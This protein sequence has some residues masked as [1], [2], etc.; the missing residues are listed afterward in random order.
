MP[1]LGKQIGAKNSFGK[2]AG[3]SQ[4]DRLRM[5]IPVECNQQL[6]DARQGDEL[7]AVQVAGECLQTG[8]ILGRLA[9]VGG[10]LSLYAR[11]TAR[12]LLYLC[13]MLCHFDAG[14]RNVEYLPFLMPLGGLCLQLCLAAR[15]IRFF[16][17]QWV[18]ARHL[19]MWKVGGGLLAGV[20]GPVCLNQ[21]FRDCKPGFSRLL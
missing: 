2:L 4:H 18:A 20:K 16:G 14:G 8:T 13:L 6:S 12:T 7:L 5:C 9:H 17:F 10:K 21:G 1:V 11:T 3:G 19:G 15:A